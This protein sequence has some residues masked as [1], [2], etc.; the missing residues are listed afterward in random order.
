MSVAAVVVRWRGGDEVRRCLRSLTEHGDGVLDRVVLVDSG[1]ADSGA[2]SLGAEFP[3]VQVVALTENRSFA[4]AAN[5]GAERAVGHFLLLLNPDAQI[6]ESTV[7]SL[8]GELERRPAC[9]GVVPMLTD[10]DGRTQHRWQLRHLPGPARLAAG[11]GGLPQYPAP[12]S[13]P[14]PVTQPA[15]A[16]WLVRRRVWDELGGLDPG[17]AP[18]WWEDVDFCARLAARLGHP[19]FPA[20][21]GFVVVPGARVLHGGGSSL[22]QLS[23][24][25]FLTAFHR[26]LLR[27][28][29]RHHPDRLDLIQRGLHLSLLVRAGLR[30]SRRA[31]YLKAL[32]TVRAMPL[33]RDG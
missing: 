18:A 9:A 25:E 11:L 31:A 29:E 21:Q 24:A 27:Y 12:P 2:E 7:P 13:E 32:R 8:L 22:A 1:S 19:G 23:D 15:A 33:E 14:A 10:L 26:N 16:A 30:P 6:T 3:Q 5:R 28:A 20:A 17:F 4:W